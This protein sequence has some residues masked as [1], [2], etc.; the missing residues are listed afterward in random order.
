MSGQHTLSIIVSFI[1]MSTLVMAPAMANQSEPLTNQ[2]SA[3]AD[4]H[5]AWVF[6][7]YSPDVI[8]LKVQPFFE[9]LG[10]RAKKP[11]AVKAS[12]NVKAL[13]ENCAA[14]KPQ[15]VVA[16]G[17]IADRLEA[18]CA[19]ETLAKTQ[20]IVSVYVRTDS[21]IQQIREIQR[22]GIINNMSTQESEY[23]NHFVDNEQMVIQRYK[24]FVQLIKY[25][26]KDEVDALSLPQMFM[27]VAPAL[28]KQWRPIFDFDLK[29]EG[30]VLV[31]PTTSVTVREKLTA[32]LLANEAITRS[33]WQEGIGL[34]E[35]QTP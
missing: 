27:K 4:A 18:L 3:E 11:I 29:G 31:S 19:Y 5:S 12:A 10:K 24:N 26:R 15:I 13:L 6:A 25:N 28:A 2:V 23:L 17:L 30:K 9:A 33:V 8:R 7:V 34:G 32:M 16:S 21:S 20:Q 35:F 14:G 1:L 22:L